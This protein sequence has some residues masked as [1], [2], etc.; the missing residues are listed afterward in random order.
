MLIGIR[1]HN[2]T[3]NIL[4]ANQITDYQ[5]AQAI[6]REGF[7]DAVAILVAIPGGKAPGATNA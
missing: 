2:G 6:A 1:H 3:S 4:E 5:E 7:P